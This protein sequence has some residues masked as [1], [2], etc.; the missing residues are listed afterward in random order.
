MSGVAL[1]DKAGWA[2][3]GRDETHPELVALVGVVML[4]L[5]PVVWGFLRKQQGLPF[6]GAPTVADL[7]TLDYHGSKR[8]RTAGKS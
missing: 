7:D 8:K 1:L 5:V 4:V 6:M 2:P 3:L